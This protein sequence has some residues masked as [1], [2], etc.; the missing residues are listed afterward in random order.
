MYKNINK[1]NNLLIIYAWLAISTGVL[2]LVA[3][4]LAG[5]LWSSFGASATFLAGGGCAAVALV[6]IVCWAPKMEP[7]ETAVREALAP[8][9]IA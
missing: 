4:A 8:H 2:L 3:S 5:L 7:G 6:G 9:D 1:I